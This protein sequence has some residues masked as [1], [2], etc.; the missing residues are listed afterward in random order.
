MLEDP[1]YSP[2]QAAKKA[3]RINLMASRPAYNPAQE[4]FKAYLARTS[5]ARSI[6]DKT[7]LANFYMAKARAHG[8]YLSGPDAMK[9]AEGALNARARRGGARANPRRS[10]F[11]SD[12]DLF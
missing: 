2:A 1:A 9:A 10:F 8:R 7:E 4:T 11:G 6:T 3:E 12:E 5:P